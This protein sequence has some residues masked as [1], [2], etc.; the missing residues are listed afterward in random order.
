MRTLQEKNQNKNV[1][2]V[3]DLHGL[4]SK[5]AE[6]VLSTQL[7]MI[8][9]RVTNKVI[10]PNTE[11]GHIYC[12]VTGKGSHGKRPVLRGMVERYLLKH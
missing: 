4:K 9:E 1:N 12:I 10:Q 11:I 5:E 6:I 8:Q 7:K 3:L 2:E